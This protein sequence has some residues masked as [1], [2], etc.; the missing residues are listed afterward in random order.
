MPDSV[1]VWRVASAEDCS[2]FWKRPRL[3]VL[4]VA[5]MIRQSCIVTVV[6][7][8]SDAHLILRVGDARTQSANSLVA[9]AFQVVQDE[10]DMW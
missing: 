9:I 5:E 7:E 3:P 2:K 10:F 6:G 8:N 4:Y 1:W